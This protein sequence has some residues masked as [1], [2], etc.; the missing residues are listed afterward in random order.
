MRARSKRTTETALVALAT[1]A[2]V[3][4]NVVAADRMVLTEYFT[5]SG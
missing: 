4:G 5:S 3:A 2:L 1:M